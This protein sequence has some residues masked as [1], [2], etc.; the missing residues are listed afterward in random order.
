MHIFC[1]IKCIEA[2]Q[3]ASAAHLAHHSIDFILFMFSKP[4]NLAEL[5]ATF[6]RDRI[7]LDPVGNWYGYALCLHW[8]WWIRYGSDLLAGTKWVHL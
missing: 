7:R 5:R 4:K 8:T 1:V 2:S 3:V 6:T